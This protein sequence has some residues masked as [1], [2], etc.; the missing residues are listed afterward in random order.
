MTADREG[1]LGD[2]IANSLGLV[3]GVYLGVWFAKL[4]V[5]REK[6]RPEVN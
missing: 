1:S 2:I 3:L 6:R 4:L 5:E